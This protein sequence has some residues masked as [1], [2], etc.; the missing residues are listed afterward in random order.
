M[1]K[2]EII[3]V[4]EAYFELKERDRQRRWGITPQDMV[5]TRKMLL[6]VFGPIFLLLGYGMFFIR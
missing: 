3:S 1:T 4:M 2:E 5:R 6:Y